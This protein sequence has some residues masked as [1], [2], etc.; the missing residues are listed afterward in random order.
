MNGAMASTQ[1]AHRKLSQIGADADAA[2]L[3]P[4]PVPPPNHSA[5]VKMQA[6]PGMVPL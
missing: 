2:Q 3:V 5:A 1:P 4:V 6:L